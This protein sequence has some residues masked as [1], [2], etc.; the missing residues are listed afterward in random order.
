MQM[1]PEKLIEAMTQAMACKCN[2]EK[3]PIKKLSATKP[4]GGKPYVGRV[5]QPQ[6]TK[7]LDGTDPNLMCCYCKDSGH[8]LE[9][10]SKLQQKLQWE[11][12]AAESVIAEKMLNKKHP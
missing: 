2:T 12:L 7:G 9:N 8:E 11:Q 1:D 5:K 4:V 10:C 3:D 6:I